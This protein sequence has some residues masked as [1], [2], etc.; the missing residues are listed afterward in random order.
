MG[1]PGKGKSGEPNDTT[2]RCKNTAPRAAAREKNSGFTTAYLQV[3]EF[4]GASP[5]SRP[6]AAGGS[7][8]LIAALN[9]VWTIYLKF[10]DARPL[11][12]AVH[13]VPPATLG[14]GRR[15]GIFMGPYRR[16]EPAPVELGVKK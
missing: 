4:F 5:G 1:K 3:S 15:S 2:L 9:K 7:E 8:V 14:K 13:G 6:D 10:A 16:S 12:L 11:S